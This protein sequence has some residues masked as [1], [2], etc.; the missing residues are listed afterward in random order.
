MVSSSEAK[1]CKLS[2]VQEEIIKKIFYERHRTMTSV[3]EQEPF[4][5]LCPEKGLLN[6][7]CA[8]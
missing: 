2:I 5:R 8:M 1:M 6:A 4:C 3:D 7:L